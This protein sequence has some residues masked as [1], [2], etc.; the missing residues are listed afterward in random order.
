[1]LCG[2]R[3]EG[4]GRC[5]CACVVRVL[6]RREQGVDGMWWVIGL[7]HLWT[8]K[9]GTLHRVI[10]CLVGAHAASFPG[11]VACLWNCMLLLQLPRPRVSCCPSCSCWRMTRPWLSCA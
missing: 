2:G 8:H 5:A 9:M 7:S 3:E 6:L 4:E 11:P 10:A 1:M